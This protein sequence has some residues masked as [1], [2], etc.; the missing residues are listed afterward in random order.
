MS[1]RDDEAVIEREVKL[2]AWPGFSLPD[3]DGVADGARTRRRETID[4]DATYYDT[5]DLRLVRRGI[6]LRHRRRGARE[7]WTLKLPVAEDDLADGLQR[8]E[9]EVR[10]PAG[11]VPDELALLVAAQVRTASL[12]RVARLTTV[13]R[14]TV[15]EGHE[16]RLAEID[17][18]EVSIM[19]GGRVAA[20]YREL[21]VELAPD[22]DDVVAA[23]VVD[24]LCAAGAEA[25]EPR[26]KVVHALGPRATAIPEVSPIELVDDPSAG[27]VV[28]AALRRSVAQIL[29]HHPVAVRGDDPE[30]VH[31]MRTGARRLRSDLRTFRPL[32]DRDVTDPLR[33]ELK[34]LGEVLGGVRDPDV[35]DERL[36][37]ATDRVLDSADAP[38]LDGVLEQLDADREAAVAALR[39]ALGSDRYRRLLD[40]LVAVA[41][42]PP[43][44][45]RASDPG[46][47]VLPGLVRRPWRKLRAMVGDVGDDPADADLHEVRKRAKQV[48]YAAQTVR[49]A[50]GK[51][52]KRAAKGARKVQDLLGDHQDTVEAEAWLREAGNDANVSAGTAFV[53]GALVADERAQ[54]RALRDDWPATWA[55]S[56][57]DDRWEWVE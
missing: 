29:D 13:R 16:G 31:K 17:D 12:V 2:F 1:A 14:R 23:A 55:K 39:K 41:E 4:F 25:G 27:E 46:I 50:V 5:R 51:P 20:R 11:P 48:R 28:D 54:R 42:S 3:L 22:V 21:E 40:D 8:Q 56:S 24:R 15:V 35:L 33:A 44:T 26:P 10:G 38:A 37:S 49:P 18:D 36:R 47:E 52:A 6:T 57:E 19:D 7:T 9:V 32:L 45:S 43:L 53:L 30:G 34:W